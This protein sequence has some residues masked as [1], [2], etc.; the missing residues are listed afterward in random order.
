MCVAVVTAVQVKADCWVKFVR[1]ASLPPLPSA[2]ILQGTPNDRV[3]FSRPLKILSHSFLM[4]KPT[5]KEPSC[6]GVDWEKAHTKTCV[7]KRGCLRQVYSR[8]SKDRI[9][10]YL[11]L[12]LI[13]CVCLVRK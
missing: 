5:T 12:P 2:T 6:C 1:R 4:H 8:L 11:D 10:P 7:G 9:D 13:V 3:L